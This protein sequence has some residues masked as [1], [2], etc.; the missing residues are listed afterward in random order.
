MFALKPLPIKESHPSF[1]DVTCTSRFIRPSKAY[2]LGIGAKP[3][4]LTDL[5]SAKS[6]YLDARSDTGTWKDPFGG[7][8]YAARPILIWSLC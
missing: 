6:K 1:E 4:V 2:R 7:K 3:G 8:L 5:D